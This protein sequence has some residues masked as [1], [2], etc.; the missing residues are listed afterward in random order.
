MTTMHVSVAINNSKNWKQMGNHLFV[1]NS[2]LV[3]VYEGVSYNRFALETVKD[4]NTTFI[5]TKS[6]TWNTVADRFFGTPTAPDFRKV[7]A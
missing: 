4:L 7:L 6:D 3:S 5:V 2:D 1:I